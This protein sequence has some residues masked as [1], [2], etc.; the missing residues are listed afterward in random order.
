MRRIRRLLF[1]LSLLT[2]LVCIVLL[3]NFTAPNPTGRRYSSASPLTSGQASPQAIGDDAERIL[4]I[5]L[6]LPNNNAPDQRVCICNSTQGTPPTSECRVCLT[7][8]PIEGSF[9]RPDFIGA[10]YIAESKNAR[11]LLYTQEDRVEQITD[12]VTAARALNQPLWLYI[13]V[14]TVLDP[15]FTALVN[16]TGGGVV[17][18][19]SVP[20]YLDPVDQ[21]AQVGLVVASL[22]LILA[23]WWFAPFTRKRTPP[24]PRDP[25]QKSVSSVDKT[26]DFAKAAKDRLRT[27]I[28]TEDARQHD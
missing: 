15:A 20:G 16:T 25:L 19:F 23:W 8:Q 28:D 7:T 26:E 2:I 21:A 3:L 10:D 5:D 14:N 9:R 4:A 13:R 6:G 12:Y 18:Y 17:R 11:N 1:L 24:K 22:G 27:K